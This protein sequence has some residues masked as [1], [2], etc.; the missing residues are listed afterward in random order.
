MS[1]LG[2]GEVATPN[3]LS[4]TR[5]AIQRAG[6]VASA[7]PPT[8]DFEYLFPQ[9]QTDPANRLPPTPQTVSALVTLGKSMTEIAGEDILPV[10]DSPIPAV[11]T[12]F[13]QFLDHDITLEEKSA[14][15]EQLSNANL[16]PLPTID[17]ITNTRSATLDLDSVYG[18][19]ID[20]TNPNKMAVGPVSPLNRPQP[21][22]KPVPG[23]SLFNDLPRQPPSADPKE[24]RAAIIGDP[25]NDENTIVAQL[26]TAFL[27]AH[28]SLVDDG[29][30]FEAAKMALTLRYQNIVLHDFLPRIC[31]P[32]VVAD[33][34][35][36]GCMC[37]DDKRKIFMPLEFAVA[38]YRFGHSMVR[39]AYDFNL[40]F[41]P[42]SG[43]PVI[44]ASLELLFTFTALSGQLAPGNPPDP[45][46][47]TPTLPEN[48]VIEWERIADMGGQIPQKARAI[49]A[50]LTPMLFGLRNVLGQPASNDETSPAAKD[51]APRL[52]VRNL[53]RGYL[54]GLPT[55]QAVARAIGVA[56]LEGAALLAALPT[57][58]MKTAAEPFKTAS[59]LWFYILAEAGNPAGAN[60]KHLGPVGSRIVAET[61]VSL[62]RRSPISA[63]GKGHDPTLKNFKLADLLRLAARQDSATA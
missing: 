24:D 30:S 19:L 46:D 51:I 63:L 31:D 61:L 34:L 14:T 38:G 29:M 22:T 26:H 6:K 28:N 4:R 23:K 33:V 37:Y 1:R 53:L 13:G 43:P 60:G 44:P 9:L 41:S 36:K 25:R 12:Y 45:A 27:K 5:R 62:I 7:L 58:A 39:T 54:F 17:G 40:N 3:T 55:G 48:W 15:I 21:P 47:A 52:A 56:P 8:S 16:V 57:A 20:P 50:R 49:D 2:H 35:T 18:G 42:F 32:A 10:G 11:F 59:P